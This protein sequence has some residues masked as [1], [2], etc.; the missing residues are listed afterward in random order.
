MDQSRDSPSPVASNVLR[1]KRNP[2]ADESA[3]IPE[4]V[5]HGGDTATVLGVADLGEEEWRG[6]LRKRVAKTHEEPSAFK[7]REA[8]RGGLIHSL[9]ASVF[10]SQIS[11]QNYLDSSSENHNRTTNYDRASSSKAVGQDRD[12]DQ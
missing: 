9:S 11:R 3:D 5:V 2:R 12:E 6:E 8:L 10:Q 1:A 7:H 4:T